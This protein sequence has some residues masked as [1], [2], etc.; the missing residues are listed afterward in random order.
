MKFMFSGEI[1]NKV[2]DNIRQL[3][4]HMENEIGVESE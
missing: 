2:I 1:C 4:M 3:E